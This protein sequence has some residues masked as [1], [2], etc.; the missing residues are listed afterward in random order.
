MAVTSDLPLVALS[1]AY[2]SPPGGTADREHPGGP[3]CSPEAPPFRVRNQ[4]HPDLR[5]GG[6]GGPARRKH[7]VLPGNRGLFPGP[8]NPVSGPGGSRVSVG[9]EDVRTGVRDQ[10]S[11]IGSQRLP[12]LRTPFPDPR[13]L[14]DG[15]RVNLDLTGLRTRLT[16]VDILGKLKLKPSFCVRCSSHGGDS[17][18]S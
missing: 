12:S 8:R 5:G 6:S 13:P 10:G 2:F 15:A 18:D 1:L 3:F 16:F 9:Q 7:S 14:I 11:E 4:V 17:Q